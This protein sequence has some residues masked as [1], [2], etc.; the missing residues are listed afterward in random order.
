[1]FYALVL[2]FIDVSP[3]TIQTPA[4][5]IP[6]GQQRSQWSPIS[7]TRQDGVTLPRSDAAAL[8]KAPH[9]QERHRLIPLLH[10]YHFSDSYVLET[11]FGFAY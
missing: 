1:M 4:L 10:S 3:F 11:P 6:D 8:G 2:L 9:K 7:P 5:G